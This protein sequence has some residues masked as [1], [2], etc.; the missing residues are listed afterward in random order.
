MIPNLQLSDFTLTRVHDDYIYNRKAVCVI[1]HV[2]T[3]TYTVLC[4][5][6]RLSAVTRYIRTDIKPS[7]SNVASFIN[8]SNLYL[9]F[10]DNKGFTYDNVRGVSTSVRK[11]FKLRHCLFSD[12]Y[13]TDGNNIINKNNYSHQLYAL[14]NKVDNVVYLSYANNFYTIED[15]HYNLMDIFKKYKSDKLLFTSNTLLRRY[16]SA[17][18]DFN[19]FEIIPLD[20]T[21]IDGLSA[22]KLI[23]RISSIL[24]REGVCVLNKV[25]NQ[26]PNELVD[27]SEKNYLSN[28]VF[29]TDLDNLLRELTKWEP[30]RD[31][32][33]QSRELMV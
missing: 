11:Y 19:S 16:V 22:T 21:A 31:Y 25:F 24:V 33:L 7:V 26:G 28:R 8:D 15:K 12:N 30:L 4:I 1:E 14:Y 9:L 29:N 20:I 32:L 17:S 5:P 6:D 27:L 23:N 3:L 18:N 2:P 10:N 13:T